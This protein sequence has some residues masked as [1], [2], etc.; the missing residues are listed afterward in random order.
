MAD[1]ALMK[2]ENRRDTRGPI[3][4]PWWALLTLPFGLTVG[5][6]SIAVP[7][8]LRSH[9]G[10][11]MVIATVSQVAQLPHVIKLLWSPALDSGPRRRT[12]Y[13]GSVAVAVAALA[14]AVLMVPDATRR[15]GPFP[16]LWVYAAVL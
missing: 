9:G 8:V 4:L 10:S 13:L 6:A 1:L 11:M 15:V 3:P 14:I 7:F 16:L 12:W 5:F 2:R